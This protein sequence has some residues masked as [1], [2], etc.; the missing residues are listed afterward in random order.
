MKASLILAALLVATSGTIALARTSDT[1]S[2]SGK[3][4][5]EHPGNAGA[6]LT[7]NPTAKPYESSLSGQAMRDLPGNYGRARVVAFPVEKPQEWS[8]SGKAMQDHPGNK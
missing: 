3:A 8:L 4:M 6:G 5:N 7:K 1:T 2:L